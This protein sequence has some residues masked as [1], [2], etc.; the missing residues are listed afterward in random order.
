MTVALRHLHSVFGEERASAADTA[1]LA[2]MI[3]KASAA[4]TVAWEAWE[5]AEPIQRDA[6]WAWLQACLAHRDMLLRIA[7]SG[8]Q[9]TAP[10]T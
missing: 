3:A 5:T 10:P 6:A 2:A 4:V 1:D 9:V 7:R 8:E